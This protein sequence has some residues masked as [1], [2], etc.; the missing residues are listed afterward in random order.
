MGCAAVL[1][2][3]EKYGPAVIMLVAGVALF[4]A[5]AGV[6][7]RPHL[8]PLTGLFD[9]IDAIESGVKTMDE[10]KAADIITKKT[11]QTDPQTKE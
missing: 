3:L 4:I 5:S 1:L 8:R 11:E 2:S 7:K 6:F 10:A 9:Q